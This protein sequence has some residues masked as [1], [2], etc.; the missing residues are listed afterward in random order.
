MTKSN[1]NNLPPVAEPGEGLNRATPL[2]KAAGNPP[3]KLKLPAD[4]TRQ[5]APAESPLGESSLRR[6]GTQSLKAAAI[7]GAALVRL[8]GMA[9]YLEIRLLKRLK[10]LHEDQHQRRDE[11]E[12]SSENPVSIVPLLSE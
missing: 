8:L 6:L 11:I 3:A 10:R 12:S 2:T 9:F 1:Y 4:K 5:L 7:P